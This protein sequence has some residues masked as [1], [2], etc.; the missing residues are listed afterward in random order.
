MAADAGI[1]AAAFRHD[2]RGVVRAAGTE[3]RRAHRDVLRFGQN[4]LRLF[5][6]RDPRGQLLVR[7]ETEQAFA[8]ADGDVV[9]IERALHREKPVALLVL[10]ADADRLVRRAVQLLAHLNLDQRALFLDDD[11]EIDAL[12][13]LQHVGA[14]DRIGAADLV[15]PQAEIVASHFVEAEF[16]ERLAHVEIALADRDDADARLA[17][18]GDDD[19]VELV[20][21]H[22]GEHGVALVILQ[23]RFHAEHGVAEPDVE[24]AR[25]HLEEVIAGNDDVHAIEIA[26]DDPSRLDRVVHAFEADPRAG[27]ARH[28]PAIEAVVDD[29]LH[30]RGIEHRDHD[31]DEVE[32]GL[33]RGGGGLGGVVVPHQR[34]H[35][36]M[37]GGAGGIGVAEHVARAVDA[38]ALAVPDAEHAVVLAFAAQLGLLRPP[39]RGRGEVLVEAAVEEDVVRLQQRLGALELLV[40]PAERRTAIA[41][42]VARGVEARAPVAFLLHQAEADDRLIAGDEDRRFPE[43]VFVG[44]RDGPERHRSNPAQGRHSG[45]NGGPSL[46]AKQCRTQ[47]FSAIWG[48]PP[49]QQGDGAFA[50]ASISFAH[51]V[52]GRTCRSRARVEIFALQQAP[53]IRFR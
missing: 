53:P 4:A 35:A 23:A 30:A 6:A 8:D 29:L 3:I 16:V 26:V 2:G 49:R 45:A 14:A 22:E 15:E 50:A 47:A 13:R 17:A 31:I 11:E 28:R 25:R 44:K 34:E 12:R 20:R 38:G 36:A 19:A 37:F 9:R 40:E 48:G 21:A 32:L 27:V 7:R 46:F 24:T 43:V 10:L 39:Q 42:D 51:A 18:A 41:G 5:Q 52:G 33:V 1:G